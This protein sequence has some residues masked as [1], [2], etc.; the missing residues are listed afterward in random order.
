MGNDDDDDD[1]D[2]E[3]EEEDCHLWRKTKREMSLVDDC[4]VVVTILWIMAMMVMGRNNYF[5]G[6]KEKRGVDVCCDEDKDLLKGVSSGV[7]G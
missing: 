7:H 1:D 5:F 3:E 2:D 6:R 4:G